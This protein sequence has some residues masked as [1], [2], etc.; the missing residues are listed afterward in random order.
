VAPRFGVSRLIYVEI[1]SFSLNPADVLELFRGEV[2]GR[3]RVVEVAGGTARVAFTDQVSATFPEKGPEHGTPNLNRA[4]TYRG[5]VGAFGTAVV[6]KFVSYE[7][8]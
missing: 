8:N 1:D 2:V 6:Q 5:A 3:V 7:T 4:L